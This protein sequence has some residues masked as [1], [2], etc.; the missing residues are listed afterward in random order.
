MKFDVELLKV[1]ATRY[2]AIAGSR[3]RLK[4]AVISLS[5]ILIWIGLD[6][7]PKIFFNAK[8]FQTQLDEY[9][10]RSKL[11]VSY[12]GVDIS[13][14]G[15]IRILGVRVSFDKDFSR[16]RYLL[17]APVVSLHIP[18]GMLGTREK[19][20]FSR[21]RVI[22]EDGKLGYWVTAD[23]ADG[24]VLQQVRV[25]LQGGLR[26]HV[27]CNNCHFSLNVKDNSYFQEVT[28]VQT[29]YFTAHHDG[30]EIQTMV[31][32]ESSIIGNG[33]FFGKFEPCDSLQCGDLQG[34]W[35]Y[36][37]SR[38][39]LALINN[40][41]KEYE[42]TSG[43]VSGEV[44]YDRKLV[45]RPTTSATAKPLP[46][47][48]ISN[49]RMSIAA[50][51]FSLAKNK[52]EWY[53]TK[54]FGVETKILIRGNSSTGSV[55]AALDDYNVI[56]DFDGLSPD[57]LPEKYLFKIEPRRFAGKSLMLPGQRR[58]TGLTHFALELSE[59][60][61]PKYD[62]AEMDLEI[63]Q[64]GLTFENMRE[65][66]TVLIPHA[67]LKLSNEKLSGTIG[68]RAGDS[69]ATS[70]LD[71]Y[72]ALYP[73]SF[74]PRKNA[75]IRESGSAE[76][77]RIFALSGR[78][79]AP[80]TAEEIHWKDVRPFVNGWLDDYWDDVRGGIQYSWLPS[81]LRRREYFVRFIQYLDLSMPIEIKKFD[82]GKSMALRGNFYFAPQYSGGGFRL[83]SADGKNST[84][85]S[86]SY[87]G[88]EPN[89]PYMTHDLK[90]NLENGYELLRP[91]FGS[92]YFEY[93]SDIELVHI[94]HFNGERSADHYLKSMSATDIRLKRVRLGS[95]AREKE[96][97]LQWETVEIRTNRQNGFGVVNSV[98]AENENTILSAAGDYKLFDRQLE[99]NLKYSLLIK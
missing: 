26:Y 39:K 5:F 19:D 97:P 43:Y 59:R 76:E 62:K 34:Y 25:F 65:K 91:W 22:I 36:K 31:R 33:D 2:L 9:L 90:L 84:Q 32:Y 95:W 27:E 96:L 94:N 44:A 69:T 41:Q 88:N 15:G 85:L 53:A 63:N 57:A 79:A 38:L 99:S 42:I 30:K 68:L 54:S 8:E 98:R 77:R 18:F 66:P 16:G 83:D 6:A 11:A 10:D 3:L 67:Q 74:T 23:S 58:L 17:E 60:R 4:Y 92:E 56:A 64:G 86:V 80:F 28:P 52:V 37:P 61:G 81:H 82:W 45:S 21:A 40:F 73:V 12:Q 87:G 7:S 49:F 47:E 20:W 13:L 46:P 48:P 72:L 71:G 93:F 51:D 35:Y 50:R 70:T 24:D 75:L 89:A 1:H 55:N 29:V 78:L 14:F